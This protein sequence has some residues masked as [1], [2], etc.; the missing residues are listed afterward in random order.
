MQI[1]IVNDRLII[2]E[3]EIIF[4]SNIHEL[5]GLLGVARKT[6]KQYNVIYTWDEHG[7]LGYSKNGQAVEGVTMEMVNDRF[8]RSL[9]FYGLAA[10]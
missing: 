2:N 9:P 5:E 4:P 10:R 8:D 7:I 3:K 6:K 1:S